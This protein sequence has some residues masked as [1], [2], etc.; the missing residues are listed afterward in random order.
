M[1]SIKLYGNGAYGTR[2]WE[3]SSEG[4]IISIKANGALY[5]EEVKVA[6]GGKTLEQQVQLRVAARI[7]N[8]LSSGFKESREELGDV[9]T[10]QIG[11]V[12][13]MLATHAKNA[14]NLNYNKMWIQPKLDGHRC[15]QNRDIMY[16]RG[17]KEITQCPEIMDAIEVPDGMTLDGELYCHGVPLQTV[18]SWAK[19]RQPDTLKLSLNVYDIIIENDTSNFTER[20][21]LLCSLIK[22]NQFIKLVNTTKYQPEFSVGEYYAEFRRQGYEGG[23]LRPDYGKY[24]PGKRSKTLLKVKKRFEAEY[25]CLDVIPDK[26]GNGILICKTPEGFAFKTVA[27]GDHYTK[28]MTL[29]GKQK[30]IG[31]MVTCEYA[32][33]SK[34]KVPQH[35]VA[36]RWKTEL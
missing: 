24:E 14:R 30:Y 31:K 35:C 18:A 29:I 34:E 25:E 5:K 2:V 20:Y 27:P 16:S 6:K 11:L 22:E 19:R 4:N 36:I 15:L 3:I 26:V 21:K 9:N 12:M 32:E 17:G 13:P 23:I 7:R 33:L 1:H 28:R 10:N 8:K